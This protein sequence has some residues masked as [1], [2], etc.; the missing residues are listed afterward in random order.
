MIHRERKSAYV[1]ACVC[2][3]ACVLVCLFEGLNQSVL[4][5]MG[6]GLQG[7]QGPFSTLMGDWDLL[8][9]EGIVGEELTEYIY[10]VEG[11]VE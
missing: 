10:K 5:T 9:K 8:F 3:R 11:F 1:F 7:P 2:V 4:T 6:S